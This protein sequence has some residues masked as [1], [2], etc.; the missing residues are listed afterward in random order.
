MY[1]IHYS[2][3]AREFTCELYVTLLLPADADAAASTAVQHFV[4]NGRV[5]TTTPAMATPIGICIA[6]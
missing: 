2:L 1:L 6:K 4:W 3:S 5:L